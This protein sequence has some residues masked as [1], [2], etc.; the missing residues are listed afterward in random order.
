MFKLLLVSAAVLP[1]AILPLLQS[2]AVASN[3][4]PVQV[5]RVEAASHNIDSCQ[6]A[7]VSV[8]FHDMSITTHS[9]KYI[10]DS[11]TQLKACPTVE[12]EIVPLIP[13]TADRDEI[14]MS[15]AQAKELQAYMSLAGYNVPILD[16][17]LE[18]DQAGDENWRAALLRVKTFDK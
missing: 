11:I 7:E 4:T 6:D 1:F 5:E 10:F 12:F 9:A 15:M 17:S 3:T 13:Q 8:Y 2:S 18:A 14:E 16:G